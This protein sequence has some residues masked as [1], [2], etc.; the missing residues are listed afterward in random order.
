MTPNELLFDLS[1]WRCCAIAMHNPGGKVPGVGTGT[2]IRHKGDLYVI[3]CA[4]VAQPEEEDVGVYLKWINF[5]RAPQ[6]GRADVE[7]VLLDRNLDLALLRVSRSAAVLL[8][9]VQPL[10]VDDL[11]SLD[12]FQAAQPGSPHDYGFS[13]FPHEIMGL[14]ERQKAVEWFPM[15]YTTIVKS[16]DGRTRLLLDYSGAAELP[17][18]PRPSG[19]SGST[20]FEVRGAGRGELWTPG[21]AVAVQHSWCERGKHLVCSPIASIR[22]FLLQV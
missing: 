17:V 11:G 1:K 4:H 7:Q 19:I 5:Y 9:A 15:V 8:H 10:V 18:M 22:D 20:V 14:S 2:A 13:G 6:V 21:K 3:T 16:N 12:D